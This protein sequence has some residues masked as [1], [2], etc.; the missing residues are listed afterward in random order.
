MKKE[1]L[2]KEIEK[3]MDE[4][5]ALEENCDTLPQCQE[6]HGCE[7]CE[8]FEKME[9]I[10]VKIEQLELKIDSMMQEEK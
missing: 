4:R 10:D 5:E 7:S 6:E 2:E 3:L 1:K 9:Q 8:I